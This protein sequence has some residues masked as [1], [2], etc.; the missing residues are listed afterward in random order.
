M[1]PCTCFLLRGCW[2]RSPLRLLEK[3]YC[4]RIEGGMAE[5]AAA[6]TLAQPL[7]GLAEPWRDGYITPW[8]A[9]APTGPE[10]GVAYAPGCPL[11]L[12]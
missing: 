10:T 9:A 8:P 11:T 6:T 2:G 4:R 1:H 12:R 7:F 3:E 5:L